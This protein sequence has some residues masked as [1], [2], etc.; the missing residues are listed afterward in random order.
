MNRIL[1]KVSIPTVVTIV[2]VDPKVLT[3]FK[4][5]RCKKPV[6]KIVIKIQTYHLAGILHFTII[7]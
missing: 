7:L 3:D 5:V 1:I 4:K 2:S 6:S